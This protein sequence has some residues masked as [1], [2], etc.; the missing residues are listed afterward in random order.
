MKL[1]LSKR[2]DLAV[3]AIRHLE[4]TRTRI[5]RPELADEIGTTPDFLA[6]VMAD[7]VRAGWVESEPGRNGGYELSADSAEITMLELITAVEGVPDDGL[8]VLRGGVCAPGPDACSLHN[9]WSAARSALYAELDGSTV[10][11]A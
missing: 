9:A 10:A 2:T 5:K 6:R 1:E 8:C 7:L 4:S 3:R 11:D